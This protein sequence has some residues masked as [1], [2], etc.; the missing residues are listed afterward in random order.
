MSGPSLQERQDAIAA[1]SRFMIT[2]A[3]R[4]EVT[5][6]PSLVCCTPAP[7]AILPTTPSDRLLGFIC[8]IMFFAGLVLAC[9]EVV[10]WWKARME[11]FESPPLPTLITYE[12][13]SN[14][15]W[16]PTKVLWFRLQR[17]I[18]ERFQSAVQEDR[19]TAA[20]VQDSVQEKRPA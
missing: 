7:G 10:R 18:P 12:L 17:T 3:V 4:A 16:R 13:D 6:M 9:Q 1:A 2:D 19:P 14:K 8:L 20:L 15:R 11:R 5:V